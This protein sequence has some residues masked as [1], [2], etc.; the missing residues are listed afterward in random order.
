MTKKAW[1]IFI[2]VTALLIGGLV[3]LS[4][5][6]KSNVSNVQNNAIL[7]ASSESGNIADHVYGNK[8]SKVLLIEYGDFQC[9]GCGS[10]HP[11]VKTLTETYKDKIAFVFRNFPLSTIHP[12]AR[13]AAAAAEAAGLQGKYWEM[14]NKLYETQ[15]AWENLSSSQ[16]T[17]FF[18]GYAASLGLDTGKFTNDLSAS[19]VTTKINFDQALGKANKVNSTPTLFLNGSI[20]AQDVW[21]NDDTLKAAINAELK[22]NGIDPVTSTAT[23]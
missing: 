16:R 11:R 23:Q 6:K 18:V 21:N 4:V 2:I 8:D 17:D 9:P 15:S 14:H 13:T 10:L 1:I 7:A 5:S 19:S 12:N 3:Y 22:K 20:L